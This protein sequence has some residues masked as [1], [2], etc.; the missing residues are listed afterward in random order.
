MTQK[1]EAGQSTTEVVT[2]PQRD[3]EDG[4]AVVDVTDQPASAASTGGSARGSARA[5]AGSGESNRRD[6][7]EFTSERMLRP[8]VTGPAEGWRRAVYRLTAGYVSP[9]PSKVELE[10][11]D[12]VARATTRITGPRRVALI[13]RKGGVG[14]TTTTLMLGH[15]FAALRGDRVVALDANPD[16]GSLGYRVRP[17][18]T[19]TVT[20][21][22]DNADRV[23]S[24]AAIRDFTSQT[25]TRLEVVAADDDPHI[26]QAIGEEEY[27]KVIG[28]LERHYNLI[29]MDTGTG[30]L[31]RA[32]QGILEMADQ[33]VLV[34]APSLDAAR[35]ASSTFDWLEQHGYSGL[36]DSAVAVLNQTRRRGLVETA[37]VEEHFWQRCGATVRI[38][39]DPYLEAG[40]ETELSELRRP[41]RD[42]YLRLAAAVADRFSRNRHAPQG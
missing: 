9:R 20:D 33:L 14:K 19:A 35:A 16:A 5:S 1:P 28:L 25:P 11:A 38:P 17:Q 21:L 15:T 31:D 8:H 4:P 40:A 29:L 42:A 30:I 32:T 26:S 13:S 18:T 10:T 39:W 2:Q 3:V 36:V 22:L 34:L 24:Y 7:T 23:D 6:A 27:R 37:R 41:T 12:L